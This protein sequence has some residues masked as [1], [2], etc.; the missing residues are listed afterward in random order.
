MSFLQGCE[1]PTNCERKSTLRKNRP[2]YPENPIRHRDTQEKQRKEMNEKMRRDWGKG[3]GRSRAGEQR[4]VDIRASPGDTQTGGNT[5]ISKRGKR[6]R[7]ILA[8][9]CSSFL[10]KETPFGATVY[11]KMRLSWAKPRAPKLKVSRDNKFY[12]EGHGHQSR[13]VKTATAPGKR[14]RSSWRRNISR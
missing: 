10:N 12:R 11:H 14:E 8:P 5:K 7:P 2:G 1:L 6:R 9:G 3:L 13:Y 4:V